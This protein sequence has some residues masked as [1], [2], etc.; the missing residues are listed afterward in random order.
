MRVAQNAALS[1]YKVK[2]YKSAALSVN[3]IRFLWDS[4]LSEAIPRKGKALQS[5]PAERGAG[6]LLRKYFSSFDSERS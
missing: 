6:D 5:K 4:G 3:I 2:I 1:V